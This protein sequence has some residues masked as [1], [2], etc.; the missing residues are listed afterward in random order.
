MQGYDFVDKDLIPED[1]N[2]QGTHV[3][4]TIGGANDNF[5]VTE[6]PMSRI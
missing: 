4:G 6:L 5:G 2:G 3:A 1:G